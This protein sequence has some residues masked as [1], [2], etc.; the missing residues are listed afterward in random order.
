MNAQKTNILWCHSSRRQLVLPSPLRIGDLMIDPV[1]S[2]LYL[3]VVVNKDLSF[4]ENVTRTT[5][6]CFAML[7][8]IR[9]VSCSLSPSLIKTLVASLVLSRLDYCITVHADLP[10]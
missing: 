6:T 7:R 8:R 1:H 2:V 9:S 10:K 4:I 5:R 3:G